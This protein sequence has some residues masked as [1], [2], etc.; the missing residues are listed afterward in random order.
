MKPTEVRDELVGILEAKGPQTGR[1]LTAALRHDSLPHLLAA[2][3]YVHMTRLEEAGR[4]SRVQVD[5]RSQ[6]LW[7]AA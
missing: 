1:E 6:I 2:D 5:A 3:V 4:V 7:V